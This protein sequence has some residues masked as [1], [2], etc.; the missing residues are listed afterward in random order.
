[1]AGRGPVVT[2]ADPARQWCVEAVGLLHDTALRAARLASA[3]AMD[4]LDA[5]GQAWAVRIDAL[6]RDLDEAAREADDLVRRLPESD[7]ALASAL[8]AALGPRPGELR[9]AARRHVRRA[10][11]RRPRHARRS[12]ARAACLTGALASAL[13]RPP[14]RRGR[15]SPS[16]ARRWPPRPSPAPAVRYPRAAAASGRCR[17]APPRRRRR[18]PHGVGRRDRLLVGDRTLIST[19]GSTRD[20]RRQLRQRRAGC[21]IRAISRSAVSRPSPVVACAGRTTCPDCSPPSVN[22]PARSSSST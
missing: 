19:C 22:P 18:R 17:P 16:P 9:A 2:A 15:R 1:M 21:A 12:A 20:D 11:R 7:P 5:D 10:G 3:V 14:R 8:A 13:R 4:W 6:R